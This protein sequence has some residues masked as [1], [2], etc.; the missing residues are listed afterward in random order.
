MKAFESG[1]FFLCCL[2]VY[3]APTMAI[4][5]TQG[6]LPLKRSILLSAV[7]AAFQTV[8]TLLGWGLSIWL[9]P[10]IS[11]LNI[12]HIKVY[13]LLILLTSMTAYM[14]FKVF[15]PEDF[16]ET[17][18]NTITIIKYAWLAVRWFIPVLIAGMVFGYSIN[19]S[20]VNVSLIFAGSFVMSLVG[21]VYGYWQG[22][23]HTKIAYAAGG[24]ILIALI[25]GQ[26]YSTFQVTPIS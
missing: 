6:S 26:L 11:A 23:K 3:V 19:L 15:Y 20:I 17:M 5:A 16:R 1:L 10:L 8:L 13:T 21:L 12:E 25:A 2:L 24:I 22:Y 18:Q 4:G 7:F 14:G 9:E